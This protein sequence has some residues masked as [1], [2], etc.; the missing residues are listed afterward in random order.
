MLATILAAALALV[1]F[2]LLAASAF[3][4]V[5]NLADWTMDAAQ[6]F[7]SLAVCIYLGYFLA[8][9]VAEV[10]NMR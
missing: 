9:C 7:L 2:V 3:L 4:G 6:V 8:A 5:T 1:G 10:R